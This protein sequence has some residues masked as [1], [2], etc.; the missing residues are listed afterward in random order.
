[1]PTPKGK[2]FYIGVR[3]Y[4]AKKEWLNGKYKLP[5]PIKIQSS[6]PIE[7]TVAEMHAYKVVHHANYL[8]TTAKQAG[9]TNKLLHTTALP[10]EGKDP[11]VT[12]ALDHL[13]SKGLLI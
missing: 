12:P 4:E 13:Y 7:A 11:V 5:V 6:K 3:L 9:G 2:E 10:T 1:M 8:R